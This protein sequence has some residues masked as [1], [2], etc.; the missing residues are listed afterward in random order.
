MAQFE[1]DGRSITV[2]PPRELTLG[3]LAFIKQ[4]YGIESQVD[5]EDGLG[6]VDP[7]SWRALLITSIREVQPDVS[8]TTGGID[9]I[10]IVPLME[11]MNAETLARL[12][13]REAE[14]KARE[15][16][17]GGDRPTGGS[18]S[19]PGRSGGRK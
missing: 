15:K 14:E 5:L 3:Q 13:A 4:Q 6:S 9:H 7:V 11:E 16:A 8:P 17:G 2:I 19:T 12:E 18:S 1:F 10:A